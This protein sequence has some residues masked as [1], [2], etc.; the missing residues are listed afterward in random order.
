MSNVMADK[1]DE[2]VKARPA[3]PSRLNE[4]GDEE[5]AGRDIADVK[6]RACSGYGACGYK[7]FCMYDGKPY[8][9]CNLALSKKG[10]EDAAS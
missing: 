10:A 9:V 6:C 7:T 5:L 4:I 8:A 2:N 3:A 1:Q